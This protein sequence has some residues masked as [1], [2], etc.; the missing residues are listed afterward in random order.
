MIIT[1]WDEGKRREA[2]VG[3]LIGSTFTKVVSRD[4]HYLEVVSGYAIQKDAVEKLNGICN[5]IIIYEKDTYTMLKISFGDFLKH[6][7][8]W[9]HGYGEQLAISEKFFITTKEKTNV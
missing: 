5:G 9:S 6:S 4:K 2:I 7:R 8:P 3:E 1:T